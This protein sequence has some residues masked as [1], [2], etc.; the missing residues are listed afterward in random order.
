M[1]QCVGESGS[2]L[3]MILTTPDEPEEDM[4][5][6]GETVFWLKTLPDMATTPSCVSLGLVPDKLPPD[7]SRDVLESS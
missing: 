1:S 7:T 6:V 3:D 2:L 4:N 5:S